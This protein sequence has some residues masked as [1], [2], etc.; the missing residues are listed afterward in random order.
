MVRVR[1]QA[2]P[3]LDLA[4]ILDE[5]TLRNLVRTHGELH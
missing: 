5:Q 3:E 2:T 4:T 1:G